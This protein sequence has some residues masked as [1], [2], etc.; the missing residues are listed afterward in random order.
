MPMTT[1]TGAKRERRYLFVRVPRC[2]ECNSPDLKPYKTIRQGDHTT[3][4]YL[5]C[6]DCGQKIIG[7]YE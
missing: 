3:S 1:T 7:V 6:L 4:R 5:R 2:P